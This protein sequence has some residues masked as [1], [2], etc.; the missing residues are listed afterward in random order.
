M[1]AIYGILRFD[2][3]AVS[4]RDM[5]RMGNA[6][7]HRGPQGR[8]AAVDG[9][10][11]L[12]HCLLRGTREDLF[13]VQPLYG[14]ASDVTLVAD[15]RIDNREALAAAFGIDADALRDMPDSALILR[16]YETWGEDCPAHL[17]GDFAFALWDGRA[18]R[19]LLGR[20]HMGQRSIFY[21]RGRDFLIFATEIKALWAHADVPRVLLDDAIARLMLV[22]PVGRPPGTTAYAQIH[23]LE[24]G[25]TLTTDAQGDVRHRRYWEPRADPAHENRDESYYIAAYRRVLEEAVA[26]RLRRL[27]RPA[28]LM[29]SGGFD[30]AAIAGLAGPT[31]T[32]QKRKLIALSHVAEPFRDEAFV[33]IRR[34]VEACRRVMPHLDVRYLPRDAA[35]PLATAQERFLAYDGPGPVDYAFY[36]GF[37]TAALASGAGLLMDGIGG[38]YTLN[39][40]GHAALA[41]L[42]RTGQIR[43]F[44][45]E[46]RPY[47]RTTRY[48]FWQ[49]LRTAVA[50][51]LAP[52]G[53]AIFVWRRRNAAFSGGV[54]S[55][56]S[57][58]F[59][60]RMLAAGKISLV[61]PGPEIAQTKMRARLEQRVRQTSAASSASIAGAIAAPHMD[62]S[63]PFHDKR[64]V[65]LALAI[66]EDLYVKHGRNRYLACRALADVYPAEFMTRRWEND[67]AAPE[68]PAVVDATLP[69]LLDESERMAGNERLSSLI[70]FTAIRRML[71]PERRLGAKEQHLAHGF[72]L[73]GL[74]IARYIEWF[75][76]SNTNRNESA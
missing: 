23:G 35:P 55:M 3:A 49:T 67:E 75:E 64:V 41:R 66:P 43:R 70:D 56:I 30:S 68:F 21:H 54:G 72:A 11:A 17:L 61:P 33:G 29:L 45:A 12:G 71:L 32:A 1:S 6:L 7:A 57:G 46:F 31:V 62:F 59:L 73:R 4:P 27:T 9:P 28:A 52:T 34:W 69:A 5:E 18:R 25:T 51:K 38:D 74:L 2:G 15:C 39:P 36:R 40:R 58:G 16:A 53:L 76:K 26:C 65:E 47:M 60:K 48:S 13:E 63:R 20:D 24:G 42:L 14:R 44:L 8:K 22:A 50:A 19:L 37:V 10:V